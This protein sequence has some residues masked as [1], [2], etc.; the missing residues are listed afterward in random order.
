MNYIYSTI[1]FIKIAPPQLTAIS[2][3]ILG[4]IFAII[5][6]YFYLKLKNGETLDLIDIAKQIATHGTSFNE[7]KKSKDFPPIKILNDFFQSGTDEMA[8]KEP[9]SWK[10]FKLQSDEY[11]I[12]Y[13]WCCEQYGDLEINPFENCTG[14]SEWFA[15]A[16][17][18]SN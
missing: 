1:C 14:Y 2:T 13:D 8:S 6:L 11:L 17:D 15:R 3:L 18:K 12:F 4:G 7:I 5:M 10:P 16:G 9:L